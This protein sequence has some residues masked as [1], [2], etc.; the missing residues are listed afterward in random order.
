MIYP[1]NE[2]LFISQ[3]VLVALFAVGALFFGVGGVTTLVALCAL[4]SN[5]FVRKQT[6]LFGL[7]VVTCDALAIGSDLAIH[8]IYEYYGKKEAQRAIW[9]CLYASLFFVVIA[10]LFLWYIPNIH[11][12]TQHEY[13]AVLAPMPWIMGTSCLVALATKALNLSLYHLFSV[14]WQDKRFLTKTIL[15]LTISQLFDTVAFTLIGLSGTVFSVCQV[16]LF[17][18]SIKCLAIFCG[19]PLVTLCRKFLPFKSFKEK[20]S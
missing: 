7:D 19:I 2:L 14:W 12:T 20:L 15:A 6:T 18:Y 8:L 13:Y 17:S 10:Q 1:L 9:V 3:S 5:I 16:I 11:D 4:L